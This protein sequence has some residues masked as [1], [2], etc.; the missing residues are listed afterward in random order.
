MSLTF[1][2]RDIER[3]NDMHWDLRSHIRNKKVNLHIR[4]SLF[5]IKTSLSQI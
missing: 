3:Y 4:L 5:T 1:F 2:E